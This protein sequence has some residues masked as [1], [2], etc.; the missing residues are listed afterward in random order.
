M[1]EVNSLKMKAGVQYLDF[2][3]SDTKIL[4][5]K[6][7][8]TLNKIIIEAAKQDGNAK[9]LSETEAKYIMEQMGIEGD[10]QDFMA[11]L[12]TMGIDSQSI[13]S[14]KLD[15]STG[16]RT[17][18]NKDKSVQ[19]F[20]SND[21]EISGT[22]SD[23]FPYETT[24]DDE[25]GT[26]TRTYSA[27]KKGNIPNDATRTYD[28]ATG[29]K[30]S[31]VNQSGVSTKF[32]Y[33]EVGLLLKENYSTGGS[34]EYEYSFNESN[35]T[36]SYKG[37]TFN[38]ANG[39]STSYDAD[40]IPTM[41]EYPDGSHTRYNSHEVDDNGTLLVRGTNY[42]KKGEVTGST[43]LEIRGY[44]AAKPKPEPEPQPRPLPQHRLQP[45]PQAGGTKPQ[46]QSQPTNNNAGKTHSS[47]ARPANNNQNNAGRTGRR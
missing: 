3:T 9:D 47:T 6:N 7:A 2:A 36:Y 17:T 14:S 26:Y 18:T 5:E 13:K 27:D 33:N 40:G 23:G 31:S 28:T 19:T 41:R 35:N 10:V 21:R 16:V 1:T 24:Y 20:D 29:L 25:N 34:K 12:Q 37:Y 32:E 38:Y 11:E 45:K 43:L 44:A 8:K 42:N 39:G 4:D 22:T 15:K 46:T 30:T